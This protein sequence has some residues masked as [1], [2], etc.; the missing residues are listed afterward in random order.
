MKLL[1]GLIFFAFSGCALAP[2]AVVVPAQ[3]AAAASLPSDEDDFPQLVA[4]LR[5]DLNRYNSREIV[6]TP[7][8]TPEKQTAKAR[9]TEF[10]E[11]AKALFTPLSAN[12]LEIPVVGVH[13]Y[14]LDDSWHAPR[15][16]GSRV[17]KGIDIFAKKGTAVVAVADGIVSYIGDQPK[18]GHC[19]WLTTESGTAFYY[20][21]LDRWAAGLYEGMEVQQGDL[22]GYVGNTGNAIHTPSH[23]H[24]G[25][26]QNDE[27][28]NPYPILT[29]ATPVQQARTHVELGGG[30]F[31]TR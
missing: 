17:H 13:S 12:H 31:G 5:S 26:N 4:Q 22:L 15:D 30:T 20:A 24:F 28:V 1:S 19:I 6:R 11:R 8:I 3:P 25:I 16:G 23:L 27:M 18:G 10:A 14:D 7:T 2:Q 21:H 29:R 9:D